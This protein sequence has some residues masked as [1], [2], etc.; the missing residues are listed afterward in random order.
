MSKDANSKVIAFRLAPE[1]YKEAKRIAQMASSH[2]KIRND[3]VNT[4]AKAC[5]FVRINCWKQIEFQ[6][7]AERLR[8]EE[9]KA[10][11]LPSAQNKNF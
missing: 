3:S 9:L 7:E 1:E 8:E 5:L 6:Q 2:G 10:Y 4:L 11:Y